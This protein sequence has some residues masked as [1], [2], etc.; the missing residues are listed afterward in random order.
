LG[1]SATGPKKKMWVRIAQPSDKVTKVRIPAEK[2][3]FFSVLLSDWLRNPNTVL[4]TECWEVFN[5]QDKV[6]GARVRKAGAN[7]EAQCMQN[8]VIITPQHNCTICG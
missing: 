2:L 8:F 4:A 7:S 3:I 6:E 1:R 5:R